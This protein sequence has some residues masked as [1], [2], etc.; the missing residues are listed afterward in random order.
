MEKNIS[1]HLKESKQDELTVV[2]HGFPWKESAEVLTQIADEGQSSSFDRES[3]SLV[4]RSQ[5]ARDEAKK[6]IA[7]GDL[8][9]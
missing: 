9:P 4:P 2:L 6:C 1:Y 3:S 8:L 5:L 7:F